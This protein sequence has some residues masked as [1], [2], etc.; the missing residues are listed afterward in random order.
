MVLVVESAF[1]NIA[2]LG[3]L[4]RSSISVKPPS[5]SKCACLQ[6]HCTYVTLVYVPTAHY[7]DR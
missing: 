5:C 2:R 1:V 7:V 4:A 3:W 6:R